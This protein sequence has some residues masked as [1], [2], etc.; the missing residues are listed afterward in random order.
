MSASTTATRTETLARYGE[1]RRRSHELFGLL[2]AEAYYAQPIALR[3]PIVFY[4][5]HLVAFAL[6]VLVKRACGRPGVDDGLERVFA[7]GIDP[8]APAGGPF[9]ATWPSRDAVA[10]F[11]EA[12]ER[13]IVECLV[14]G[15]E[16]TSTPELAFDE[17]VGTILEH[18]EMHQETLL[19]MW[20]QLPHDRKHRPRGL[21]LSVRGPGPAPLTVIVPAGRATLG[22]DPAEGRF[23]WDN[24]CPALTVDV[25]AFEIAVHDVTNADFLEFVAAGGYHDERWWSAEA[26]AWVLRDHRSHPPFWVA[27]DEG[28]RWRGMFADEPLPLEWPVYVSHA[29]A[30]AFARW[31]GWRLPTEAEFHRAAY[32]TPSGVER[33]QPWGDATPSAVHGV[34]DFTSWDPHP[35]GSHPAGQSAW[36]V[37]DMV[38]NGWEWT[39]SLFEPFPG[40]R[41]MKAYPEYSA[42]FF[43]GR[44]YVMK[45]ASPS[46]AAGLLRRS[47]RNWFRPHYPYVYATF[48]CVRGVDGRP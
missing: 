4:E 37:H 24:E 45:G 29:E 48:R 9:A 46:T 17:A 14:D 35:A 5:G 43:D 2:T 41:A 19:Y 7:R 8:D 15:A 38:G 16:T 44:H 3:H 22:A 28:W 47:F 23:G 10:A 21:G 27:I 26:Y 25:P 34:F 1:I 32:G 11:V 40:F 39:A 31:R 12:G 36:G 6:N 33:P 30:E 20:H 42:D 13:R 18:E